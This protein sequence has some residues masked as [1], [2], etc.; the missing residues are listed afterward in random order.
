[1]FSHFVAINA[2][3]GAALGD[4]RVRQFEPGHASIT[5]F[6]IVEGGLRLERQGAAATTQVL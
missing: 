2:A 5:T 1:V 6:T 3:V 4:R